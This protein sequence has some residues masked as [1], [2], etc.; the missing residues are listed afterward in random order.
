MQAIDKGIAKA[1]SRWFMFVRGTAHAETLALSGIAQSAENPLPKT[2][3]DPVWDPFPISQENP[4][5]DA[6][7][8]PRCRKHHDSAG[9]DKQHDRHNHAS[10]IITGSGEQARGA[11]TRILA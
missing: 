8:H 5:L 3:T 11:G 1:S 4:G 2:E 7:A 10:R 9:C 6:L